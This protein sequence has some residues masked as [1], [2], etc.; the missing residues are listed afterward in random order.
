VCLGVVC[1]G[2]DGEALACLYADGVPV[3]RKGKRGGSD[4]HNQD[5]ER[6]EL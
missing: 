4:N 6:K 2:H 5:K 1:T 3:E